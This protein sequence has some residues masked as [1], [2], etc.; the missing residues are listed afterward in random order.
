VTIT[1]VKFSAVRPL[2][3]GVTTSN[4]YVILFDLRDAINKPTALIS[5][6]TSQNSTIDDKSRDSKKR[7]NR[8]D[9]NHTVP[10]TGLAFNHKQRD[11]IAASDW[12]GRVHIWK[13][14][15]HLANKHTDEQ[16]VLDQ[17]GNL[18]S[19]TED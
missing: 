19:I 5:S 13:L 18:N 10:L 16:A 8:N 9:K 1:S 3:F 2:L 4:G 15:W 12:N 14:S 7:S 17:I 11:L 6:S